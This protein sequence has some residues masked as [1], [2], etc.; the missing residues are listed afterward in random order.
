M[1][2]TDSN[3]Q[4]DWGNGAP[5][6]G[7]PADNFSVRWTRDV[8][9][10]TGAYDFFIRHDDGARVWVD[11]ALIIDAWYDQSATTHRVTRSLKRGTHRLQIEYYEHRGQASVSAWVNV[12]GFGSPSAPRAEVIVDNTDPGFEWGG[13]ARGRKFADQGIGN[14]SYW[15]YNSD[16]NP[17]NYC[18][19]VPRLPAAGRYE[20]LVH[21]PGYG[22]S[23]KVMYRILH[24]DQR[25]DRVISQAGYSNQWVSLGTYDF[26]A[27]AFGQEA[28]MV[29]DN[30]GE[31]YT[32][33][34]IAFDA[35]KFVPR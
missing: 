13:P 5:A 6:S 21:L 20:V 18:K 11:G 34:V 4:F 7:F 16:F 19:W 29:Y 8:Y 31:A 33:R 32:S 27:R 2:R 10:E 14:S 35:V 28:V 23:G 17:V 1:S 24:N 22:N 15:T 3:I 26:N 25:H 9:F 12:S 30:T